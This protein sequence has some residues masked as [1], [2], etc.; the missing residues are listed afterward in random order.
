MTRTGFRALLIVHMCLGV[1]G[2]LMESATQS[3]LPDPLI[4]Y[5]E[6]R[7][8]APLTQLDAL[9]L[10]TIFVLLATLIASWVGLW[11][12]SRWSPALFAAVGGAAVLLQPLLG[13][14]VV[15]GWAAAL[16][17]AADIT[18]GAVLAAV[19]LTDLR[20][21]FGCEQVPQA[22]ESH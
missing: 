13:P 17:S 10:L 15:S 18:G 2:L 11:R 12:F 1:I 14:T 5:I 16:Y 8:G 21:E 6:Q 19:F 4:S 3:M 7:D 22:P 20:E 9:L